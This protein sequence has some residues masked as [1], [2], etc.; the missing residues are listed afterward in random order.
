MSLRHCIEESPQQYGL[1]KSTFTGKYAI[2]R[3]LPFAGE[4]NYASFFF[5]FYSASDGCLR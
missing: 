4:G 5:L 1:K 3:P 2:E